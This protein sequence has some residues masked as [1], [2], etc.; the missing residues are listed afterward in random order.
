MIRR[1]RTGSRPRR[2]QKSRIFVGCEGAS[3]QSYAA[4][5]GD[6]L[7]ARAL[8]I[9]LD[10]AVLNPGA[11][12]P[13]E[14]VKRAAAK[15][16]QSASRRGAH[17]LRFLLLDSDRHDPHDD[18][19]RRTLDLARQHEIVLIWQR[20]CHEALLL[21]HLPGCRERRPSTTADAEAALERLW[22]DYEKGTSRQRLSSRIDET[23]GLRV[24]EVEPDLRGFL[25]AISLLGGGK[26]G[27]G[28]ST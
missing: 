12:D 18:L 28:R 4:L 25:V 27:N 8:A 20:P 9:H 2:P 10:I 19:G 26:T 3:A 11:G 22:P 16:A 14:L 13:H 1:G 23:A 21:R 15:A 17:V 5:L 6:L 7:D 24:A